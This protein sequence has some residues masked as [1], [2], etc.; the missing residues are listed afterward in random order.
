[1]VSFTQHG[2]P[3][4]NFEGNDKRI[5][6]PDDAILVRIKECDVRLEGRTA[7]P[8]CGVIPDSWG[9]R[10]SIWGYGCHA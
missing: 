7:L 10:G 3:D 1:M 5:A 2:M 4:G 6:G 9:G 8:A